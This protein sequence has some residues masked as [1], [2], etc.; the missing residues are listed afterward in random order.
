MNEIEMQKWVLG[1]L[2]LPCNAKW[3]GGQWGT[4]VSFGSTIDNNF[5][6][7]LEINRNGIKKDTLL[8]HMASCSMHLF[9]ANFINMD[10]CLATTLSSVF[11]N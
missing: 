1:G 2:P 9:I 8:L 4:S 11:I 7:G 5:L 3:L 10:D 6:R